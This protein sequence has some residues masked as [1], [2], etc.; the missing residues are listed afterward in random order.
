MAIYAHKPNRVITTNARRAEMMRRIETQH[1]TFVAVTSHIAKSLRTDEVVRTTAP[2]SLTKK[3]RK[4]R[5]T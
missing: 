3:N 5:I 2:V 1:S 4:L